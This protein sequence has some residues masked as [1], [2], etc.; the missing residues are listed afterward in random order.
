M[1]QNPH[2]FLFAIMILILTSL[3]CQA[4]FPTGIVA[5]LTPTSQVNQPEGTAIIATPLSTL[6]AM[7]PEDQL[8]I[9]S[10]S[11]YTDTLNYYNVSGEVVN[12]T[13]QVAVHIMLSL[14]ITDQAGDS[15]L[16]DENGNYVDHVEIQPYF[17]E[18][19]PGEA[20]P[21]TY[22]LYVEGVKPARYEVTI[23]SFDQSPLVETEK[24]SIENM[25]M[26]TMDDGN[27]AITGE[28]VNQSPKHVEVYPVTGTLF[29][30]TDTVLVATSTLTYVRYL[31]PAG[32]AN[33]RDR[34]PFF[35][36]IYGPLQNVSQYKVQVRAVENTMTPSTDMDVRIT[37]SYVDVHGTYHLVGTVT[38]NG[39]EQILPRVIGSLYDPDKKTVLDVAGTSAPL[40]LNAGESAPFDLNTFEL[41]NSLSTAQVSHLVK[42][43]EPDLYWTDITDSK[44]VSLEANDIQVARDGLDW[45]VSGTVLNTS[46]KTLI[47][48]IV[49]VL[50]LDK[51]LQV[52]ATN[53]IIVSPAMGSDVMRPED[54]NDFSIPVYVAED[55]DLRSQKYQIILQ[56]LVIE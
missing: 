19:E 4:L 31:N 18:V 39:S 52:I 25:K 33:G 30:D 35:I 43:V 6:P 28:L 45:T 8:E 23:Q 53:S 17:A 14:S 50:F 22:N 26:T 9:S 49:V 3:A 32:D 10:T 34:S 40:Y 51:D 55:W 29:D 15:L 5:T 56:G 42:I 38:N 16:R 37:G 21:F 36:R 20:T 13:N 11:S 54:S 27:I 24:I 44:V 48:A 47:G 7:Q 2:R 1:T 41:I 46:Q 12:H